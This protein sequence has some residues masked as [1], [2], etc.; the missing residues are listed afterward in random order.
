MSNNENNFNERELNNIRFGRVID[1]DDPN[2]GQRIRVILDN[3]KF[4]KTNFEP[5][6]KED[7]YVVNPFL[8]RLLNIVPKKGDTV[9]VMI[10]N[11]Y[12]TNSYKDYIGPVISQ[13][14]NKSLIE[15]NLTSRAFYNDTSANLKTNVSDI[16]SAKG[17][18]PASDYLG[19]LNRSNNDILLGPDRI[20]LRGGLYTNNPI[21]YNNRS[22][23]FQLSHFINNSSLSETK[24][25]QQTKNVVNVKL[26]V[27][28]NIFENTNGSIT[29]MVY[30]IDINTNSDVNVFNIELNPNSQNLFLFTKIT[31]DRN[32]AKSILNNLLSDI[33]NGQIETFYLNDDNQFIVSDNFDQT[34]RNSIFFLR[35]SLDIKDREI[36]FI[37]G[38]KIE[39]VKG[40]GLYSEINL[41]RSDTVT[42]LRPK[43][44]NSDFGLSV[45]K[46]DLI[47]LI[48]NK[49]Q[50]PNKAKIVQNND[51]AFGYTKELADEELF[52]KTEGIVRGEQ[53]VKVINLLIDA[54]LEHVH[55]GFGF[56][57]IN[58]SNK[59]DEL[60]KIKS[61][62]KSLIV[63]DSIRIN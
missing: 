14:Q 50:I 21:Q 20:L 49:E 34:K 32:E 40:Y 38:V 53:L 62:I 60:I 16:E 48:S 8:P 54:F 42:N 57:E 19:I 11:P 23:L 55:S 4:K 59:V 29:L 37:S 10:Y 26:L 61:T 63:N 6:S 52:K 1:A 7:P 3:D 28:Y 18:Y 5:W 33:K 47:Y 31:K 36:D 51:S 39:N 46:T 13:I 22:S 45:L 43:S 15:N 27:V 56:Q 12:S 58:K 2:G 17:I 41:L 25:V 35:P 24:I 9:K 30:G 44:N